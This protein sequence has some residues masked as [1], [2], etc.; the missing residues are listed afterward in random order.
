MFIYNIIFLAN[1]FEGIRHQGVPPQMINIP[2]QHLRFTGIRIQQPGLPQ[3][4]PPGVQGI[5]QAGSPMRPPISIT[6]QPGIFFVTVY[7]LYESKLIVLT[8]NLL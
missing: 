2:N 5:Q 3:Q 8:S 7:C 6:Q 1:S 4:P